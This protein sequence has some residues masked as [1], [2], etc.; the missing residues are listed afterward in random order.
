ME[1]DDI[2]ARGK[3]GYCSLCGK[4]RRLSEHKKVCEECGTYM[5]LAGYEGE[6]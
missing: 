5:R 3:L 4:W 1:I 6:L 2:K